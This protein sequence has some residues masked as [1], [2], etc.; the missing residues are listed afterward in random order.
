MDLVKKFFYVLKR[1]GLLICIH[2][3]FIFIYSKLTIGLAKIFYENNSESYWRFR[4]NYCWSLVGGGM[5]TQ[6]LAMS[7]FANVHIKTGG[8]KKV[9]DFG[10]ATGESAIVFRI[11][12]PEVEILL[13][14]FVKKGVDKGISKFNRFLPIREWDSIEKVDLVYCSNVIEHVNQPRELMNKLILATTKYVVIQCPYNEKFNNGDRLSKERPLNEH[15]WTIDD[16]FFSKY[17][18]DDRL[19]WSKYTGVVPMAWEGGTQVYYLGVLKD[20]IK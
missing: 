11:F 3:S 1:Q 5:Q 12:I 8:I 10:C 6:F 14:D 2:K 9:L 16:D 15:I 17:I 4:I 19:N 13:Y 18:F 7:L 20:L